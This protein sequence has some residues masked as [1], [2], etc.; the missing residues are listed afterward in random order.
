[1]S[2]RRDGGPGPEGP[3]PLQLQGERTPEGPTPP[4][5]KGS[6]VIPRREDP[7]LLHPTPGKQPGILGSPRNPSTGLP[8]H[9]PHY[10][11]YLVDKGTPAMGVSSNCWGSGDKAYRANTTPA[12]HPNSGEWP[13]PNPSGEFT[14]QLR[15]A[16]L[17]LPQP[18]ALATSS[19]STHP[20]L[21]LWAAS[22]PH[23]KP[24]SFM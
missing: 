1:M 8:G 4:Q 23:L 10:T 9:S 5:A 6:K 24:R 18:R 19:T 13:V 20:G 3:A 17:D 7:N 15:Q 14:L 22:G 21:C 12:S 11:F 16:E 2:F